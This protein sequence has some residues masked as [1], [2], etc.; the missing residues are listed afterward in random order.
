MKKIETS[1]FGRASGREGCSPYPKHK[2]EIGQIV[3]ISI[4]R[5]Y[6]YGCSVK[7]EA[8]LIIVGRDHDER[9]RLTYHLC[10]EP[11]RTNGNSKDCSIF[12]A[13]PWLYFKPNCLERD[14]EPMLHHPSFPPSLPS[15]VVWHDNV[16]AYLDNLYPTFAKVLRRNFTL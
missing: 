11:I 8:V 16:Q 14:V 15:C 13:V 9:G 4:N 6:N 2:Y 12:F 7:G 1:G 5:G 10:S 3:Q